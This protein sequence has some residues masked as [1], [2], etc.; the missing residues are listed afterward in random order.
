[1]RPAAERRVGRDIAL[2]LSMPLICELAALDPAALTDR[3]ETDMQ[4]IAY[5]I[6]A[7]QG[8]LAA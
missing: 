4:R 6:K 3:F 1:M 2:S 5:V 8:S 7:A